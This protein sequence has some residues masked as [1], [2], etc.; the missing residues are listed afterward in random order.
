MPPVKVDIITDPP[1]T[2]LPPTQMP[3]PK[4]PLP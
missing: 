4:P 1:D 2:A 3:T